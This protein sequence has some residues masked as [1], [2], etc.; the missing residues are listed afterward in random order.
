MLQTITL[1]VDGP[2]EE[3]LMNFQPFY[4]YAGADCLSDQSAEYLSLSMEQRLGMMVS[5]LRESLGVTSEM[6]EQ[7]KVIV[8]QS[9]DPLLLICDALDVLLKCPMSNV[10]SL[11]ELV[12]GTR[13]PPRVVAHNE[14][15]QYVYSSQQER[16]GD[17][18]LSISQAAMRPRL[19]QFC[20]E[21]P[22]PLLSHVCQLCDA[23]YPNKTHMELHWRYCHGGACRYHEAL[24]V[25]ERYAP[26]VV[27]GT[28]SRKTVE[29]YT[30]AYATGQEREL[31]E[32]FP[33]QQEV[34]C[35]AELMV[36]GGPHW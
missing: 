35:K 23:Q 8:R 34:D 2:V 30:N 24:A 13:S 33:Q 7:A 6:I 5:R 21:A 32:A 28:E 19:R 12:E 36:S 11:T 1:N 22:Q 25:L 18:A 9:G 17:V 16:A 4:F 29:D 26:H 31:F 3:L 20:R 15:L 14:L 10:I 27:S